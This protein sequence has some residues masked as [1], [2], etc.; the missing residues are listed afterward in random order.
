MLCV[1]S[2]LLYL[3]C[4]VAGRQTWIDQVDFAIRVQFQESRIRIRLG[5]GQRPGRGVIPCVERLKQ[6]ALEP[7]AHVW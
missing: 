1:G 7:A 2:Q 6:K 3:N 4:Q 5:H